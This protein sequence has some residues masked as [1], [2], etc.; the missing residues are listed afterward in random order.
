MTTELRSVG[1]ARRLQRT[2]FQVEVTGRT[3]GLG[4]KMLEESKD[5]RKTSEPG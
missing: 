5:I 2:M 4:V 3:K 1:R